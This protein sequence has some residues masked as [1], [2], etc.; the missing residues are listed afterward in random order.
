MDS[1]RIPPRQVTVE[2]D[3]QCYAIA[4]PPRYDA[5]SM[6]FRGDRSSLRGRASDI[7]RAHG[8]R[9]DAGVAEIYVWALSAGC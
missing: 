1:H 8:K 6:F 2:I 3:P 5:R 9:G 4:Q 7:V